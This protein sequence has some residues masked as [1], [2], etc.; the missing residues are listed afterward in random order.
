ME[1]GLVSLCC[2]PREES[3]IEDKTR[4]DAEEAK[5]SS[6]TAAVGTTQPSCDPDVTMEYVPKGNDNAAL[7]RHLMG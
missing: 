4:V 6:I 5:L 7:R 1:L 3:S 2:W